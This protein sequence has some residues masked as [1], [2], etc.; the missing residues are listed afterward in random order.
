MKTIYGALIRKQREEKG[1]SLAELSDRCLIREKYLVQAERGEMVLSHADLVLVCNALDISSVALAEGRIMKKPG[2]P[3]LEE[4]IRKLEE[5][6]DEL[7]ES[8]REMKEAAAILKGE[9]PEKISDKSAVIEEAEQTPDMSTVSE[10]AGRTPEKA[11]EIS[12]VQE[13]PV[14]PEPIGPI[15]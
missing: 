6:A 1:L 7:Q 5:K 4:L 3:E 2:V 10:A 15:L 14:K 9:E 8:I 13:D 11:H 12:T